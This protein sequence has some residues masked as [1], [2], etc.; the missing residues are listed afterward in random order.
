MWGFLESMDISFAWIDDSWWK[1]VLW[2]Y[3]VG[4]LILLVQI[5]FNERNMHRFTPVYILAYVCCAFGLWRGLP[6]GFS[7]NIAH[8]LALSIAFVVNLVFAIGFHVIERDRI[9]ANPRRY[10]L[11]GTYEEREGYYESSD[12]DDLSNA[13]TTRFG[14][15]VLGKSHDRSFW[16]RLTGQDGWT[17]TQR[18][19]ILRHETGH[20]IAALP[21]IVLETLACYYFLFL[22]V[23][24]WSWSSLLMLSTLM[25]ALTLLSWIDELFSDLLSGPAGFSLSSL[26]ARAGFRSIVLGGLGV[27]SH[28]P[29]WLRMVAWGAIPLG[30]VGGLVYMWATL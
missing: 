4:G 2:G 21:S 11:F 10:W 15:V 28:P 13:Y 14:M 20:S 19:A 23:D 27:R 9:L 16:Q 29:L 6:S 24:F 17:D 8:G 12:A 26:F 3:A 5:S 30:L 18:G 7:L 25:A 22:M 1:E